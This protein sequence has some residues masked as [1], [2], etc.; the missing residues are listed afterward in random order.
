M[1]KKITDKEYFGADMYLNAS[2]LKQFAKSPAHYKAYINAPSVRKKAFDI[3]HL[4]HSKILEGVQGW[5]IVEGHRG[6]KEVKQKIAEVEAAGK[7][8]IKPG[9]DDAIIKMYESVK[10]HSL[11]KHLGA[12]VSR[13]ELAGF[14][15]CPTTGLALKAKFDYAPASGNVLFDLKTT[16]NASPKKFKWSI[17][18][19]GY[20]IQAAHYLYVAELLGLKYEQ[21]VFIAVESESPY[22]TAAYCLDQDAL[23][24]AKFEYMQLLRDFKQ[25]KQNDDFSAGYSDELMEISF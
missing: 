3:G 19:F 7:I 15:E 9:E 10:A 20:D 8:A 5:E 11:G 13:S 16:K 2:A 18:D 22:L 1:L 6:G 21:F 23:D 17:K 25:C 4:T 12:D 14:V 24:R